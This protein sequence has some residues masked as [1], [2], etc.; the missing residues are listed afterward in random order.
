[1]AGHGGTV[2]RKTA[3]KK[4][5]KLYWPS[6]KRSP[7]RLIVL[8]EPKKFPALC[9]RSVPPLLPWT[10]AP[11][12]SNSVRR[13]CFH[14]FLICH[15]TTSLL[16]QRCREVL[17]LLVHVCGTVSRRLCD[18]MTSVTESS[19]FFFIYFVQAAI[20]HV[21]SNNNRT[22]QQGTKVHLQLPSKLETMT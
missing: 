8:L 20:K 6:R 11:Q 4:L 10:G 3:N 22:G 15:W 2:S 16:P 13:H 17:L 14:L 1:M 7:K 19:D 9:A 5:N 18:H 21:K 12:P